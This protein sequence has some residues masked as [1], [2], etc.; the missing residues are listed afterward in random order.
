[1]FSLFRTS[2][3]GGLIVGFAV[4]ISATWLLVFKRCAGRPYLAAL[5]TL[6]GAAASVPA[7]GTR[8]QMFSLLLGSILLWLLEASDNVRACCGG[9][10]R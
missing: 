6:W 7:W 1:M 4:V 5:I 10:P 8:P 2:G 3:F 9:L